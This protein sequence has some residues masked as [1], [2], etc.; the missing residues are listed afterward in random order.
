MGFQTILASVGASVV[1]GGAGGV[2]KL[3]H[4]VRAS[5]CVDQVCAKFREIQEELRRKS[6]CYQKLFGVHGS[7]ETFTVSEAIRVGGGRKDV[8][9]CV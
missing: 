8:T 4:G 6:Y 1:S 9:F 5:R 2:I 3:G 7:V